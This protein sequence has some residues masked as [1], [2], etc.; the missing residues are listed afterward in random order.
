M[1]F[2]RLGFDKMPT[3][4]VAD[5]IPTRSVGTSRILISQLLLSGFSS[6][7]FHFAFLLRLIFRLLLSVFR[8]LHFPSFIFYF[9]SFIPSP[10]RHIHTFHDPRIT[11]LDERHHE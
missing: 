6:S 9:L 10:S 5:G 8:L 2:A 4:S 1:P 11:E 3:Q 7:I